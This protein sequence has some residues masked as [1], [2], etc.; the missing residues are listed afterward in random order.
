MCPNGPLS[1][2]NWGLSNTSATSLWKGTSCGQGFVW[3][4]VKWLLSFFEREVLTVF[5]FLFWSVELPLAPIWEIAGR[6]S[7]LQRS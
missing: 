2:P 5:K 4:N 7:L 3:P 1:P 6:V